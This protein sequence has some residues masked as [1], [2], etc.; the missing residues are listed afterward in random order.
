MEYIVTAA[1]GLDMASPRTVQLVSTKLIRL[2]FLIESSFKVVDAQR[3]LVDER[4]LIGEAIAQF[5]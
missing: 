2:I 4:Q 3:Q 1:T 5:L